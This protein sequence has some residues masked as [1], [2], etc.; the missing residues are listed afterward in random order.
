MHG[1]LPLSDSGVDTVGMRSPGRRRP[2]RR[3][4]CTPP[5]D[6]DLGH[7]AA[8]ARY[9]GSSEHKTAPSFAGPPRPR[10]DASKCDPKLADAEELTGWLREAIEKGN[11]GAPFEGAYP[12]YVWSRKEGVV[13]EG[14]LV[15]QELGQYKGYPLRPEEWS[16]DLL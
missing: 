7:A 12:R 11:V 13:Y 4:R 2:P 3:Q 15:N 10:A 5:P 16:G 8:T 1:G 6:V 9:I 14:R